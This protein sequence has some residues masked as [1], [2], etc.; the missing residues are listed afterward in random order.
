MN[1][2]NETDHTASA[3]RGK[4]LPYELTNR[5]TVPGNLRHRTDAELE[6]SNFITLR[7]EQICCLPSYITGILT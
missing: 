6:T 1:G 7:P 4:V 2:A 3:A 5:S